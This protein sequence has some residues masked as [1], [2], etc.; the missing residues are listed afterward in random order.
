M[1]NLWE[2]LFQRDAHENIILT[3]LYMEKKSLFPFSIIFKILRKLILQGIYHFQVHPDTFSIDGLLTLR[4]PHPF[5][6]IIHRDVRIGLNAAI[7]HNV[8][9]GNREGAHSGTPS[10]G[11]NFYIGTNS[12]IL[13]VTVK[14]NCIIGAHS[15][16]LCNL[17][18][19]SKVHGVIK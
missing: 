3:V 17:E 18:S 16:I 11:D 12:T 6:I 19:N 14:D 5:M 2:L 13:G 9:I 8:T 7:F 10:I 1:K 4:L 15:L